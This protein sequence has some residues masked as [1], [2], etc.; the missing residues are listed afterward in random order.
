M[1]KQDVPPSQVP[2]KPPGDS[3]SITG[4]GIESAPRPGHQ[5]QAEAG[6]DRAEQRVLDAGGRTKKRRPTAT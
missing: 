2:T 5:G 1:Q 3:R 6:K 4:N